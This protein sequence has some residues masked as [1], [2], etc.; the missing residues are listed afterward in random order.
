MKVKRVILVILVQLV[1]LVEL[2]ILDQW[3]HLVILG[4]QVQMDE[5][6]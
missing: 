5:M 1:Q 3:V 2:V 4:H 6:D